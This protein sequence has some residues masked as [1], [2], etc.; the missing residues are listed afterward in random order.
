MVLQ[1]K[2]LALLLIL[3]MIGSFLPLDFVRAEDT[4]T[5]RIGG[6]DRFETSALTAL[7]AFPGG[8]QTVIIA[9]GDD[10]GHYADALT[11]SFLAGVLNAPILLTRPDSLPAQ[12]ASAIADLNATSAVI[13]GGNQAVGES[14]ENALKTL[15]DDVTRIQG[16]DRYATAA[17]ILSYARSR[18]QQVNKAFLVGGMA[19]ADSLTA[20]PKAFQSKTPILL[21]QQNSLPDV[22]KIALQSAGITSVTVVGGSSVVGPAVITQLEDL[23]NAENIKVVEGTSRYDT[24]V[25]FAK[26][27]FPT[28]S[29]FLLVNGASLVDA[30]GAAVF[31]RPVLYTYHD[32]LPT[33]VESHI[34]MHF[35]SDIIIMGGVVA[36]SGLIEGKWANS[37][38]PYTNT[39]ILGLDNYP[40]NDTVMIVSYNNTTY[41]SSIIS[42]SRDTYTSFQEWAPKQSGLC[43]LA[44]ASYYGSNA[45]KNMHN[46]AILT[47]R[48][49]EKLLTIPI[50][51]YASITFEGFVELV[52]LIGSVE[53]DVHPDFESLGIL[54]FSGLQT[55]NG[56][57]ALTYSRHRDPRIKEAGSETS[58]G[59]RIRRNQRMLKAIFS[60]CKT[61]TSEELLAVFDALE[62]DKLFT[63]MDDWD[64]L[65]LANIF[66]DKNPEDMTSVVLPGEG[67]FVFQSNINKWIWYVILNIS[68]TNDILQGIGLK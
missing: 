40:L 60:Q 68:D 3:L 31:G 65:T 66:Y 62:G 24:S 7:E 13:L 27:E 4:A 64:L 1:K 36:V 26:S 19:P 10:A 41:E 59:D 22:T 25:E 18:G 53:I 2:V 33:E 12:T 30:I 44:F 14:V 9:R 15:V 16:E 8:A 34:N 35:P 28:T 43:H 58:D 11:G 29:D 21:T 20:G 17:A 46:G 38:Y 67:K 57:Q 48:T 5:H 54:P 55:L 6:S 47:V 49:I 50:H 37:T 52:D 42:V 45:G 39:L 23:V 63:S 56:N 61:L 32:R 51:H